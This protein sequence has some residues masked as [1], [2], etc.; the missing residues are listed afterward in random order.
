M[1][2]F[3]G[4]QLV[5]AGGGQEQAEKEQD[6]RHD[7]RHDPHVLSDEHGIVIER[8]KD[9]GTERRN[10]DIGQADDGQRRLGIDHEQD[11]IY[12]ADDKISIN[13]VEDLVQDDIDCAA[14]GKAPVIE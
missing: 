14:A 3:G 13:V 8:P 10:F 2:S 6:S 1:S 5:I 4:K 7:R 12:E 11:R 9:D